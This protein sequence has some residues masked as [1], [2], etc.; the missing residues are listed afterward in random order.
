M[1]EYRATFGDY[2]PT[3]C[4]AFSNAEMIRVMRKCV[5]TGREYELPDVD[6]HGFAL[7]Y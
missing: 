1:E 7:I 6:E 2:F 4:V 5:E 3:E